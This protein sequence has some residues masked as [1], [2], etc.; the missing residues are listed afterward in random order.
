[1]KFDQQSIAHLEKLARI[2][3]TADER[4]RLTSQ[5][6]AIVEYVEK[7]QEVDTKDVAP[8]T[9]V[10]HEEGRHLRADEVRPG[11]DRDVV[12]DNAPDAAGGFFRVPR[13]V[14]R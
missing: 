10:V 12:L 7:L 1:M 8:T 3:L 13:I 6:S 14:E 5:L 11:L 2:E 4:K 9:A